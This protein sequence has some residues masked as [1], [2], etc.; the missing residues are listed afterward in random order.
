MKLCVGAVSPRVVEIAAELNVHQIVASNAQVNPQGG[1]TGMTQ[2]DLFDVVR[3]R[4]ATTQIIRDHGGPRPGVDIHAAFTELR[5]D[6]DASFSGLHLDVCQIPRGEQVHAL[7]H[8]YGAFAGKIHLEVGGEHDEPDWNSVLYD[9]VSTFVT[10]PTYAV[11]SMNTHAW[12]DKNIGTPYA[13]DRV[14]YYVRDLHK[15]GIATKA[16]NMDH[17]ANRVETYGDILDAYN[18][19]PEFGM[20]ET[21]LVLQM[22]S[23]EVVIDLLTYAWKSKKWERWFKSYDEGTWIQQA[24]CALR[25]LQ[26][27]PYVQERTQLSKLQEKFVRTHLSEAIQIG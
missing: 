15:E 22:L 24:K 13:V 3:T 20:L 25:Y 11:I 27:D 12:A 26:T 18:I 7:K 14:K 10:K 1:Y 21:E 19:A 16:H 17:L 5:N 9:S 23:P 2:K 4:S 8:L 6:M